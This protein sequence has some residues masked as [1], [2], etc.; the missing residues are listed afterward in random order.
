MAKCQSTTSSMA[1]HLY[2]GASDLQLRGMMAQHFGATQSMHGN[3]KH[4]AHA[5]NVSTAKHVLRCCGSLQSSVGWSALLK[6]FTGASARPKHGSASLPDQV[7]PQ[8]SEAGVH[9]NVAGVQ[10]GQIVTGAL[11]VCL[12]FSGRLD[13][14]VRGTR[15]VSWCANM[16]TIKCMLSS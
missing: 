1:Q 15:T 13:R 9:A 5:R 6:A 14:L 8:F 10:D 2:F 11:S 4:G 16:N 3:A 7:L 12:S